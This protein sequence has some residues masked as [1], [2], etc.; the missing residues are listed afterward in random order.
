MGDEL[1]GRLGGIYRDLHAHP[2]LSFQERRTAGIAAGWLM[3]LGFEVIEGIATTGVAGVLRNGAGPT[4]LLRADMDA[5]PVREATGLAYAS[6]V[7]GVMHACGHDMHVTCLLGAASEL[8]ASRA[9]WSGT[10]VVVFQPAEELVEG[11]PR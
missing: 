5:L 8:A 4:V 10:V 2:E 1:T 11:E 7:D 3:N 6:G 9:R